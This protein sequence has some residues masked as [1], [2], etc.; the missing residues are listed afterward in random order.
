MTKRPAAP[1]P[2]SPDTAR[3]LRT[4]GQVHA[5]AQR[6]ELDCHG[7]SPTRCLIL[8]QLDP[9]QP[10]TL[11]ELASRIGFDK[12]WTSRAVD[13]LLANGLLQKT[14]GTA[15][16]RTV[17][18]VITPKGTQYRARI[19]TLLDGQAARVIERTPMAQRAAVQEALQLILDAYQRDASTEASAVVSA[20]VVEAGR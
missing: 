6:R 7:A 2:A 5:R 11:R 12:S 3:L 15:D 20:T 16:R 4:L 19:D 18:L 9:D 8:T 1:H 14:A 17:A 13:R 10:M